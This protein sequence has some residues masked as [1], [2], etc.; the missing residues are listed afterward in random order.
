M[1]RAQYCLLMVQGTSWCSIIGSLRTV[2][3]ELKDIEISQASAFRDPLV[4]LVKLPRQNERNGLLG[5]TSVGTKPG[6]GT[7]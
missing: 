7:R 4:S 1:L 6:S 3:S 2:E 5:Y